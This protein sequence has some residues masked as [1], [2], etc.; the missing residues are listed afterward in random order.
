MSIQMV[1][2]SNVLF[3][4]SNLL[5]VVKWLCFSGSQFYQCGETTFDVK[6]R[7]GSKTALAY[8]LLHTIDTLLKI[9]EPSLPE[10]AC[11]GNLQKKGRAGT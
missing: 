5:R 2:V 4:P 10:Q 8:A 7:I 3:W 9:V 1:Q 11:D 6:N